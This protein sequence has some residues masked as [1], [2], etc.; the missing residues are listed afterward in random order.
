VQH[1]LVVRPSQSVSAWHSVSPADACSQ[2]LGAPA[3][4]VRVSQPS[5]P[6]V[7]QSALLVQIRGHVT[8]DWQTLPPDP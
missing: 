5:P 4:S 7:S 1:L 2:T 6:S 8:A 3:T